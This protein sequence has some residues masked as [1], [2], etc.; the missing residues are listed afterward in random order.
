MDRLLSQLY[1]RGYTGSTDLAPYSEA[2]TS[3]IRLSAEKAIVVGMAADP[4]PDESVAGF[5]GQRSVVGS[6]SRRP[7]PANSLEVKC[8]MSRILFQ[9]RVGLIGEIPHLGRQA[10]IEGPEVGGR[11]VGQS[12][13]VLP[14]A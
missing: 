14:A 7:E 6:D 2:P 12:G 13:V 9:V 4:E 5:H 3:S 1:V 11:V 10:P 8:G